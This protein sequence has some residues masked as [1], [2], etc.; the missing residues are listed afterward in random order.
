[1]SVKAKLFH[2]DGQT[3]EM[4]ES[5]DEA[6]GSRPHFCER[7]YKKIPVCSTEYPVRLKP[8]GKKATAC[9]HRMCSM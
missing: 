8:L 7:A 9:T 4:T 3:D 1:M 6:N 5:Y 2:A